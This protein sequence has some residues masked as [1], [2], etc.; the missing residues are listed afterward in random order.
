M[1]GI[2]KKTFFCHA[3]RV[4]AAR[5][6]RSR[7]RVSVSLCL[8][9]LSFSFFPFFFSLF[10]FFFFFLPFFFLVGA[11]DLRL[12]LLLV[13]R[14]CTVRLLPRR[15]LLFS[16]AWEPVPK[17]LFSASALPQ[18][19]LFSALEPER[20]TPFSVSEP[21]LKTLFLV[22]LPLCSELGPELARLSE[23]PDLPCEEPDDLSD[24][25]R[26]RSRWELLL[27]A[28]LLWARTL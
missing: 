22:L 16:V 27:S 19:A 11:F 18:R 3:F 4:C 2:C 26:E 9:R 17:A 13:L 7:E 23:G 12:L 20:R 1:G 21:R 24:A 10:F 14:T 15:V 28:E 25:T 5:F 6:E 8:F